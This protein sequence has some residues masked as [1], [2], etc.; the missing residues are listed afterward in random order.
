[1][2]SGKPNGNFRGWYTGFEQVGVYYD[3]NNL[4]LLKYNKGDTMFERNMYGGYQSGSG[5]Q[6]DLTAKGHTMLTSGQTTGYQGRRKDKTT[7]ALSCA[8]PIKKIG[9][10]L[11]VILFWL[12]GAGCDYEQAPGPVT[13]VPSFEVDQVFREFYAHLGGKA[14]LGE[15]ISDVMVEGDLIVQFLETG[16]MVLDR[17]APAYKRFHFAPLASDLGVEEPALPPP[18]QPSPYY[19]EG[20]YVSPDFWPLYESLGGIAFVGPP[21]TEVKYQPAYRRYEQY[22]AGLGFYRLEGSAEVH[23]LAYG[24]WA[25]GGRC[26]RPVVRNAGPIE[27]VPSLDPTFVPFVRKLGTDFTG[28]A[29]SEAYLS[30]DGMWKQVFENVVLVANGP[31]IPS[32]VRLAMLSKELKILTEPLRASSGAADV[33]FYAV[34][35]NLGYDVPWHFWDYIQNHGGVDIFGPPITHYAA[36]IKPQSHHQCFVNLCLMDEVTGDGRVSTRPEPLGYAYKQLQYEKE[37]VKAG[38]ASFEW[39]VTMRVWELYPVISSNLEQVIGVSVSNNEAPLTNVSPKLTLTLMDGT[40][41]EL[42][43][44]ATDLNGQSTMRLGSIP[45]ENGTLIPYT[46]CISRFETEKF[47]VS[48]TYLIWNNP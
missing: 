2:R 42:T 39:A 28:F 33:Y 14:T 6:I 23:L 4:F 24:V 38:R 20:H 41:R 25:C 36:F 32:T 12:F 48:D 43:M 18:P 11:L 27:I 34:D 47:C 1:L 44:P 29:I 16:K 9:L 7:Q 22:F 31:N 17:N 40:K 45:A 5:N 30:Q 15:P 21:V 10:A 13:E 26:A 35:G 8:K 37:L 46:V 19:V 3:Q